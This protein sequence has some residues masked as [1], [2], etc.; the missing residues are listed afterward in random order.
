LRYYNR[1]DEG[2]LERLVLSEESV[3]R[4]RYVSDSR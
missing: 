3:V 4:E 2:A 1:K